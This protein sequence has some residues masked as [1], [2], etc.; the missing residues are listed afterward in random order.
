MVDNGM[1]HLDVKLFIHSF[2]IF[3]LCLL[4]STSAQRRS[5]QQ[6]LIL[7]RSWHAGKLQPTVSE[8]LAQGPCM[9]VGVGFEPVTLQTQGTE[10]TTEPAHPTCYY[11]VTCYLILFI[12]IHSRNFFQRFYIVTGRI[13]YLNDK[14]KLLFQLTLKP[15]L[16]ELHLLRAALEVQVR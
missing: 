4:K 16:A 3:L 8:V 15:M 6:Q 9:A 12:L 5:W 13:S 10:L 7:C 2:R 14:W 1:Q 11:H